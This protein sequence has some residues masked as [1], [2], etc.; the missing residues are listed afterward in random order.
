MAAHG[1]IPEHS[2]AKDPFPTCTWSQV[3]V[4]RADFLP[5]LMWDEKNT[6]TMLSVP[7]YLSFL[8]GAE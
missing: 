2:Q 6:L 3:A 7:V 8:T 4:M 5:K 1:V